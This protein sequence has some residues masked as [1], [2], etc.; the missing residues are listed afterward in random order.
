MVIRTETVS[1]GKLAAACLL[2]H[3]LCAVEG[4]GPPLEPY[5]V[6]LWISYGAFEVIANLRSLEGTLVERVGYLSCLYML[7]N[8]L[9]RCRTIQTSLG[10]VPQWSSFKRR[11]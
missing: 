6:H 10:V 8:R 7:L 11:E 2:V 9:R 5:S 1:F 3:E 4:N